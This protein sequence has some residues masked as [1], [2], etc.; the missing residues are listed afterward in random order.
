MVIIMLGRRSVK[1]LFKIKIIQ[2]GKKN[3]KELKKT[4]G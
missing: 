2:M 1:E 3:N 4:L